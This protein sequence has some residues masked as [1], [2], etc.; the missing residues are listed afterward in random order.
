MMSNYFIVVYNKHMKN[1][2]FILLILVFIFNVSCEQIQDS[3]DIEDGTNTPES[4]TGHPISEHIDES[5]TGHPIS[6]HFDTDQS[7]TSTRF[8]SN[9][10]YGSHIRNELDLWIPTSSVEASRL[11]IF[12]HGGGFAGGDKTELSV[13]TESQT[14]QNYLNKNTAIATINYPFPDENITL[15]DTMRSSSE[16]IQFLRYY[17]KQI[18]I[19]PNRVILYGSSAGGGVSSWLG[20]HDDLADPNSSSPIKKLSTKPQGIVLWKTQFTYNFPEWEQPWAFGMKADYFVP[21]EPYYLP[22]GLTSYA[23]VYGPIGNAIRAELDMYAMMD[24]SDPSSI[25]LERIYD[26]L[27]ATS[28]GMLRHHDR[29]MKLLYNKAQ[30]VGI[31]SQ[32]LEAGFN[33]QKHLQIQQLILDY[34]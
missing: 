2:N 4:N 26:P 31:E 13:Q 21:E 14:I 7:E 12:I 16:A 15:L 27:P 24:G 19:D 1:I 18:N 11:V 5:N 22:Y 34:L 17:A 32:L 8:Y 9:V 28:Q 6:E 23:D 30:K 3:N 20:Y 33:N 25:Y 10:P 29:H